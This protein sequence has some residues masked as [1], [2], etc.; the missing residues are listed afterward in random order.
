MNTVLGKRSSLCFSW[1]RQVPHSL[2]FSTLLLC[3]GRIE[4]TLPERANL[5]RHLH[6][7]NTA[8]TPDCDSPASRESASPHQRP[9]EIEA[10]LASTRRAQ[11]CKPLL[12]TLDWT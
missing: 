3:R 10:D 9:V 1:L 12:L 7:I 8:G 6:S 5:L 2:G 11:I 4:Q